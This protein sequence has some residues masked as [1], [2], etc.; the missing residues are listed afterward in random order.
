MINVPPNET[1]SPA[2]TGLEKWYKAV[3][4]RDLKALDA[5]LAEECIFLSPVLY[6]PQNGKMLTYVYLVAAMQVLGRGN[7]RYTHETLSG[8]RAVLEFEC[9]LEDTYLNGVDIIDFDAT[10]KITSFKVMIRPMKALHFLKDQ[11][12]IALNQAK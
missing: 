6:T 4:K 11:M 12:M 1:F 10:G 8:N 3:G 9:Q 7:F 5:I 2:Q